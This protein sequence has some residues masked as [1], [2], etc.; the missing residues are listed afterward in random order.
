MRRLPESACAPVHLPERRRAGPPSGACGSGRGSRYTRLFLSAGASLVG[1][2]PPVSRGTQIVLPMRI[3]VQDGPFAR[4]STTRATTAASRKGTRAAD[5]ALIIVTAVSKTPVKLVGAN[6]HA[7]C[8]IL[9]KVRDERW[10]DRLRNVHQILESNGFG[11][12]PVVDPGGADRRRSPVSRTAVRRRAQLASSSW[13]LLGDWGSGRTL[14]HGGPRSIK[15]AN[16][17]AS[18]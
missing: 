18:S 11:C 10:N 6:H 17:R 9:R 15:A 4:W 3:R 5:R 16:L 2:S 1:P 12:F 8:L 7:V 14:P 13:G